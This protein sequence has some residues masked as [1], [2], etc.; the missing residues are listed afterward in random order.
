MPPRKANAGA[1][2]NQ[3]SA[4]SVGVTSEVFPIP[5]DEKAFPDAKDFVAQCNKVLVGQIVNVRGDYWEGALP[6]EKS[7]LSARL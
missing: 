2:K 1:V 6:H 4:L 5:V 7:L 3:L